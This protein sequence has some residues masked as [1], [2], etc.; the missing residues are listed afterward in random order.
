MRDLVFQNP[1]FD[2]LR[3]ALYH[4]ERQRFLDSL[5]RWFNFAIIILGATAAA[6]WAKLENFEDAWLELA[7]V[8]IAT[9]QLVFD[10]GGSARLHEFLQMRHYEV[11]A[12]MEGEDPAD[13]VTLRKWSAK[14]VTLSSSEPM[15][16][17][18]LDAIAYNK[19]LDAVLDGEEK[20]KY[21]QHVTWWQVR[22]R[23]FW[24][25]QSTDFT[26]DRRKCSA[27]TI[28]SG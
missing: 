7:I 13:E 28:T 24:A 8:L 5:N 9:I 6:K 27:T 19:A 2:A 22:L 10:F 17:R 25:F 11:L 16:M 15:T 12:E 1:K 3:S 18:A 23:H 21:R 4:T 20:Y 14:L 26:R